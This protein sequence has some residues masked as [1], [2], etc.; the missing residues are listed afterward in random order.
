MT[1]LVMD[2]SKAI[3]PLIVPASIVTL[4]KFDWENLLTIYL[5][6]SYHINSKCSRKFIKIT[7]DMFINYF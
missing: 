4:I 3:K 6:L 1:Q 2:D 5:N 7:N